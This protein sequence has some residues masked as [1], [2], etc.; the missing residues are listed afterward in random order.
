MLKY[1]SASWIPIASVLFQIRAQHFIQSELPL[2]SNN[3]EEKRRRTAEGC[4]YYTVESEFF[5]LGGA[6]RKSCVA[7]AGGTTE[8][9]LLC[10][11][12]IGRGG[13]R[14]YLCCWTVTHDASAAKWRRGAGGAGGAGWGHFN[15]KASLSLWFH[16][17]D[18][19]PNNRGAVDPEKFFTTEMVSCSVFIRCWS[20][21][22]FFS[23]L[24][25]CVSNQVTPQRQH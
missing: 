16:R 20:C 11:R 1:L 25:T 14:V 24:F 13:R 4:C 2:Q 10:E 12:W 3:R 23:I 5:T 8:R 22:T 18:T 7:G 6:E 9:A 21:E 19:A 17:G 15:I